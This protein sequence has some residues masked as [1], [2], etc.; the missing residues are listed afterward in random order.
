MDIGIVSS[1]YARALLKFATEAGESKEV[2][3]GMSKLCEA[4]A[5]LPTLRATLENPVLEDEKKFKLLHLSSG[6][7][8]SACLMQFFR[9]LIKKNRVAMAQFMAHSYVGLYRQQQHLIHG[10][11]VVPVQLDSKTIE[12]LKKMVKEKTENEVEFVVDIDPSIIGGFMLE[13]DTYSMD[14]SIRGRLEK[15]KKELLSNDEFMA[16]K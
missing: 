13:Y 8:K 16:S 15:M 5:S 6:E 4:Y 2:Y 9:L 1:R 12:R 10:R 14:A 3:Q 7:S 11:L